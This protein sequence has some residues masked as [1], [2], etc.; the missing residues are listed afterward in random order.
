MKK[1]FDNKVGPDDLHSLLIWNTN[2]TDTK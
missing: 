2:A 1:Y